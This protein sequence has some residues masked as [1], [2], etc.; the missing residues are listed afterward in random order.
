MEYESRHGST[1]AGRTAVSREALHYYGQAAAELESIANFP[2]SYLISYA[3]ALVANG[4]K[5]RAMAIARDIA[6]Y[7]PGEKL[8]RAARAYDLGCLLALAGDTAQSLVWLTESYRVFPRRDP[9]A[10]QDPL[11]RNLWSSEWGREQ[12][13]RLADHPLV[14]GT[15]VSANDNGATQYQFFPDRSLWQRRSALETLT[16]K[17][18][19][20]EGPTLR[21]YERSGGA[22]DATPTFRVD[23][24]SLILFHQGH[25]YS[26]RRQDGGLLADYG[27][28]S[29]TGRVMAEDGSFTRSVGGQV[30]S[31][32]FSTSRTLTDS[33]RKFWYYW[34]DPV[35][36]PL[37]ELKSERV[38]IQ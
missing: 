22:P 20:D 13:R 36:G 23:G 2:Y 35:A 29:V 30:E 26:Y 31:G 1:S 8:P 9:Y 12:L 27:R 32:R 5:E 33:N 11:L 15:W 17:W 37:Y 28:K 7:M 6:K 34:E 19:T 16:G 25:E 4:D 14:G 38:P 10:L 24:D 3:R 21:L 18:S